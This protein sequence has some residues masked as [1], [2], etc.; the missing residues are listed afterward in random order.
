[1]CLDCGLRHMQA[2]A[3]FPQLQQDGGHDLTCFP[4]D[5][6]RCRAAISLALPGH[7]AMHQH[8]RLQRS[9]CCAWAASCSML[10]LQAD[11][12]KAGTLS[13]RGRHAHLHDHSH[14]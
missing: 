10:C 4:S 8:G 9:S 3:L 12:S 2:T 13:T 14:L 11:T 1:M 7:L 6:C 5:A